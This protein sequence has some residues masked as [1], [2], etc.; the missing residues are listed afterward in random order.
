MNNLSEILK[1]IKFQNNEYKTD[2]NTTHSYINEFYENKFKFYKNKEIV[3]AEIGILGSESLCMWAEY[4]PRSKIFGIDHYAPKSDMYKK[5]KNIEIL[6]CNAYQISTTEKLPFLDIVIDDGSHKLQDQKKFIEIYMPK[7]KINSLMI[8][9][10]IQKV[11]YIDDL[12]CE[13]KKQEIINNLDKKK[14]IIPKFYDLIKNKNRY[15]DLLFEI[16][17]KKN[18]KCL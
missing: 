6:T 16:S 11:D 2:K 12:F 5:Y 10:D 7:M 18:I 3:L 15:D 4:F 17:I 1:K 8:I 14:I 13:C 9:E